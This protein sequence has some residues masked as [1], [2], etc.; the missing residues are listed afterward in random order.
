MM[1]ANS[2]C[3]LRRAACR[4]SSAGSRCAH[5]LL[6]RGDVHRGR[7]GVVGGLAAVDVVVGMHRRLAAALAAEQLVGAAGDHLVGVHVGLG[8]RA[9]LP[10]H[11]RELVVELAVDHLLRGLADRLGELGIELAEPHVDP[12]RRELDDAERADQRRRHA[13]AA[14]LEV[15]QRALGLGAPVAVGLDLDRA[16]RVGLDANVLGVIHAAAPVLLGRRGD[17]ARGPAV[18]RRGCRSLRRGSLL[19]EAVERHDLGA[20]GS[21]RRLRRPPATAAWPAAPRSLT[22]AAARLALVV[23]R[24]LQAELDAGIGEHLDRRE[25]DAQPLQLVVEAQGDAR[26]PRRR[27][28]GPRT[29]AAARWSCRPGSGRAGTRGSRRPD[30]WVR[31]VT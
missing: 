20:A 26:S 10:D 4:C 16:E 30:D 28:P 12:G 22:S 3:F 9:G 19:A 25:R 24:E 23:D 29:G 14:D 1:S 2:S 15:L 18:N 5:G 6:G 27:P 17:R 11:E 8:A 31:K 21:A 7:E 13:L